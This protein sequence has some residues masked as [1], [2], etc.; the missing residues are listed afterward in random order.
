VGIQA[1]RPG[2]G[3]EPQSAGGA[4]G[5][6]LRGIIKTV[7]SG[8]IEMIRSGRARRS[9]VALLALSE[10][11]N[12]PVIS[13]FFGIIIRMFYDEHNPPHIHAEYQG[14]KALVDFHGNVLRG[15]LESRTALKLVRDWIDL[16]Y[17]ELNDNWALAQSGK[18]VHNIEPLK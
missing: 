11:R 6:R 3:F 10:E 9:F 15:D 8:R 18:N 1:S 12:M 2:G 4:Y 7:L 14:K 5:I 13:T 17:D 16:H